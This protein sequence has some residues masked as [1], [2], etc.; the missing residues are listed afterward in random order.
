[1]R[2]IPG[3]EARHPSLPRRFIREDALERLLDIQ[4]R[5]RGHGQSNLGELL[6][7]I[8]AH[9]VRPVHAVLRRD[10]LR[11]VPEAC[12]PNVMNPRRAQAADD[13]RTVSLPPK[14]RR[15]HT[16]RGIATLFMCRR[17]SRSCPFAPCGTLLLSLCSG[18]SGLARSANHA[19][20]FA[21]FMVT[22]E[23]SLN[24]EDLS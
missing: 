7:E 15:N 1:M 11:L 6:L 20:R 18:T 8:S 12:L 24:E 23:G 10:V 17:S 21:S 3:C 9:D 16:A 2:K 13:G 5:T 22:R 4:A 19:C 14:T